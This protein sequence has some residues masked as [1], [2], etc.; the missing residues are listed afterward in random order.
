MPNGFDILA[1]YFGVSLAGATIVPI[2]ARFRTRELAYIVD[3]ADMACVITN[4]ANDAYVNY[5]DLLTDSIEGE[6]PHMVVLGKRER[7]GVLT[8]A[9]FDALGSDVSLDA[10]HRR[11]HGVSVADPAMILYTSGTTADPRGAII[12]HESIVRV[13]A[14]AVANALR[15]TGDDVMWNPC[16]M[17]HIA[18]LG[19]SVACTVHGVTIVTAPFFE[20]DSAVDLLERY[21]P[22]ALFPAYANILLGVLTHPRFS[23]VKATRAL[24]V[25]PPTTLR[26]LQDQL[27]G[28]SLVSTF[29]MTESC[30]CSTFSDIDDPL[31]DRM[32]DR[33]AADRGAG[34]ADRRPG[35]RRAAAAR[36]QGRD[37]APRPDP[38]RR[39]LQGPGEDRGHVPRERL[40]ADR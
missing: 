38:L 1:T 15:L 3:N 5:L 12:S 20:P 17:F 7:E 9:E 18:A 29:G 2:N 39:L 40:D 32:R 28:L 25:G 14:G 36:R 30:G 4:D 34:A 23:G 21:E 19:V 22:T 6:P 31:E 11:R 33:R 13:W 8:D 16:P 35:D 24:V 27:P 10:V 37:P 26:S